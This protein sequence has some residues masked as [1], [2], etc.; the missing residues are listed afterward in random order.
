[1][2]KNKL[3]NMIKR[4]LEKLHLITPKLGI[5]DV[6]CGVCGGKNIQITKHKKIT[7][8]PLSVKKHPN[9]KTTYGYFFKRYV[10]GCG[11][12]WEV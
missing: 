11:N 2:V 4:L 12:I 7:R 3:K 6:M 1:M 5:S 8:P 9:R 10:C